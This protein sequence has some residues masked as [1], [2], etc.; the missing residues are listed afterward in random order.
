MTNYNFRNADNCIEFVK[1]KYSDYKQD[2]E[3]IMSYNSTNLSNSKS[4]GYKKPDSELSSFFKTM[5]QIDEEKHYVFE[6]PKEE[7]LH[8]ISYNMHTIEYAKEQMEFWKGC[9]EDY[10][11]NYTVGGSGGYL[12]PQFRV[13]QQMANDALNSIT[14]KINKLNE[15]SQVQN[16]T[17]SGQ[18]EDKKNCCKCKRRKNDQSRGISSVWHQP[19]R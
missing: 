14:E 3:T 2:V 6:D 16:T 5:N 9:S 7:A 18:A 17:I 8:N 4:Y 1:N 10:I 19:H 11:N 12:T 15:N 13:Q